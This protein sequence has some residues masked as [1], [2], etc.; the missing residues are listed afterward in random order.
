MRVLRSRPAARIDGRQNLQLR[1]H[2]LRRLCRFPVAQCLSE[3][4]RRF[5]TPAHSSGYR[6]A[7]RLVAHDPATFMTKSAQEL[8]VGGAC[9]AH[10][11]YSGHAAGEAI[12]AVTRAGSATAPTAAISRGFPQGTGFRRSPG[13][14]CHGS[15][16]YTPIFHAVNTL[17]S[18]SYRPRAYIERATL[19]PSSAAPSAATKSSKSV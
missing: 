9:R 11:T 17:V 19:A 2:L 7:P 3:L 6:M 1:M 13:G 4:R 12:T 16:R 15:R 18:A 10:R 8:Y 14:K 5:C